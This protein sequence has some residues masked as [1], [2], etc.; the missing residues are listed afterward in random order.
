MVLRKLLV[1]ALLVLVFSSGTALGLKVFPTKTDLGDKFY[2]KQSFIFTVLNDGPKAQQVSIG[3]DRDSYYLEEYVKIE[4]ETFVLKPNSKK[5]IQLTTY[6]PRNL[7]PE[8]HNLILQPLSNSE[9]GDTTSYVFTVPGVA[10]PGLDIESVSISDISVGESLVLNVLLDNVGNVIARGNAEVII[11]NESGEVGRLSYNSKVLVMPFSLYNLTLLYDASNL[12][13]G[14]YNADVLFTFNG[15]LTTNKVTEKFYVGSDGDVK[16]GGFSFP[17]ETLMY[18]FGGIVF[19]AMVAIMIKPSLLVGKGKG[20]AG[21]T[22]SKKKSSGFSFG[23]PK[24]KYS[25]EIVDKVKGMDHRAKEIE[26]DLDKIVAA[27]HKFVDSSNH[28][29]R[30]KYPD[31]GYEFK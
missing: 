11:T 2:D 29:L 28:W 17:W 30:K 31:R 1:I 26:K 21:V 19:V 23:A 14:R 12:A 15:G 5:N 8:E 25:K 10:K 22:K 20:S 18:G 3:I 24:S 9:E 4:P 13:P 27:T 16:K 7:S 6:F